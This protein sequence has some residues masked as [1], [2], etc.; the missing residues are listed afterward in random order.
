MMIFEKIPTATKVMLLAILNSRDGFRSFGMIHLMSYTIVPIGHRCAWLRQPNGG[1]MAFSVRSGNGFPAWYPPLFRNAHQPS[2]WL[3]PYHVARYES[4]VRTS[5]M[6]NDDARV[7]R[8]NRVCTASSRLYPHKLAYAYAQVYEYTL[9]ISV[10]R[11]YFLGTLL[12]TLRH[13]GHR[14]LAR[15]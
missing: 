11:R 2:L 12:T 9:T 10:P 5:P 7:C 4:R 8:V 15:R 6:C 1:T 3:C 13:S 14:A